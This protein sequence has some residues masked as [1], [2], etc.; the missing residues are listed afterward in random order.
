MNRAL[1]K[2]IAYNHTE[3]LNSQKDLK[4]I[5]RIMFHWKDNVMCEGNDGFRIYKYTYG[6]MYKK[7]LSV[8]SGLYKKI[9]ATHSFVALEMENCPDW[10]TAFW[11]ILMSGNKPYLVNLRY[12]QNFSDSIL[13]TLDIKYTICSSKSALNTESILISSLKGDASDLP[14]DIFEDEVA[15][16]SSA[17][18][19]NEVICFYS[20]Y[21]IAEQILN[22][23][24][25][26]KKSPRITK[27]Y[28]GSLKQLAFLPFYHVFGL[29]AVYFW[30]A[31]FGRTLV[32]LK[33]YSADTILKTCRRHGVT[34]I[35]AVPMLWNTIEKQI[36]LNLKEKDEKTQKK[37]Q[38]G[39]KLAVTIQNIFPNIGPEIAKKIMGEVTEKLFGKSVYFCI[40]GGSYLRDSALEMVNSLGYCLYNG[41]GMSEIGITSVELR[42]TPKERNMNSIGRPFDSVKYELD[43]NGV[44]TV[45]GSSV[46]TKK[47]I[48][49]KEETINGKFY[50]GDNMKIDNGYYYIL[51]R[52]SDVVIGEN[53]E[54]I[55]PDSIE[56]LFCINGAKAMSVLGIKGENGEE[57]SIVVQINPFTSEKNISEIKEYVYKVNS[58]LPQTQAVRKFYFTFDD[59]MPPTAIKVSRT[60]LLNKIENNEVKIT[61]FADL[62]MKDEENNE[63]VSPLFKE[64]C[65]I[66]AETLGV[67][68]EDIGANSH[69][70]FDL[71]ATSIQYFTIVTTLSQ[72]FSIVEYSKD[73]KYCYTPKE[74][75][76]YIERYL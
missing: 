54:N 7:I 27:H 71:G 75:C 44:L 51:G 23:K 74:I 10:I 64:V 22:F 68:L 48:N 8:A 70:F 62:K 1:K 19:M 69:I 3:L 4:S 36:L 18:S 38:R 14:D 21:Q 59:L 17:T 35:F 34:H 28:K 57:L 61:S 37:F 56:R 24:S 41:Y 72:R 6:E 63:V 52:C 53:G 26:I 73:E 31:F 65:G 16:S 29:F 58:T 55:N 76:E 49:G 39:Q 9:G 42:N 66:I 30:F 25:I 46:C 40:N 67:N 47:L 60:Q 2:V 33:D 15:F 12:P 43:E 45:S 32:F 50:T 5:F 11:A 20:G 13:N